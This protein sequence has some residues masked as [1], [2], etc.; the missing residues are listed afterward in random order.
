MPT[1]QELLS[2]N[3]SNAQTNVKTWGPLMY[4]ALEHGVKGDWDG[5]K[6]TDDTEAMQKLVN[7]AI[8]EGRKCIGLPHT[9]TGG[10]YY[11]TH[12]DDADQVVF[13]GD[14]ASFVGGFTGTINQ[15]G[16]FGVPQEEFDE[17]KAE[18]VTSV[19]AVTGY[20]ADPTGASDTIAAL[21][22]AA[23]AAAGKT[24][25][26]PPGD[27]QIGSTLTILD[28]TTVFAY[29]ARIFNTTAPITLLSLGSG[30]KLF[31]LELEGTGNSAYNAAGNGIIVNGVSA[32]DRNNDTLIKDC[33]IHDISGWAIRG[34][35]IKGCKIDSCKLT[36]LGYA[37]VGLESASDCHAYR[38]HISD[39]SPG[40]SASMY[41][42]YFSA[43]NDEDDRATYPLSRNC[44][45]TFNT[46][47]NI[48]YEAVDTHGGIGMDFSYNIITNCKVGVAFVANTN[49]A[50]QAVFGAHYARCIGNHITGRDDPAE[51]SYGI[52]VQGGFEPTA[53]DHAKD[54]IIH[55]NHLYRC[56]LPGN[57]TAGAIQLNH[58][59]NASVVGNTLRECYAIGIH[60]FTQNLGFTI[61]GNAIIDQQDPTFSQPCAIAIRSTPNEGVISGNTCRRDNASLNTYVMEVGLLISS[62]TN[63]VIT[64]G[65]NQFNATTPLSGVI[66]GHVDYGTFGLAGAKMYASN[67]S[68]EGVIAAGIGSICINPFGGAGTTFFV[69]QT[70]TGN[71][72]WVGK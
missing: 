8:A 42:I 14:N 61:A 9:P 10:M 17:L 48:M 60:P 43:K 72:G 70:G 21:T 64:L 13:V 26:L 47:S 27:Y 30:V 39:V 67:G 69:K 52:V 41:G 63:Q 28:N 19:N 23:T 40:L 45:A 37:G 1:V 68:P 35:F 4:N 20:G 49:T 3:I 38:N 18:T 56:S 29:G 11:V 53:R 66:G 57:N 50:K 58:T 55:G 15:L 44:S 46:I 6:G 65:P 71:T 16:T 2:Q 54:A 25:F 59:K 12:L 36:R 51:N 7:K 62:P 32:V 5:V 31:G 24:L 33:Y 22:A 34:Q